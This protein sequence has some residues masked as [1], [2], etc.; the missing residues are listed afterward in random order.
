M[1]IRACVLVHVF[2]LQASMLLFSLMQAEGL[3]NSFA[4]KTMAFDNLCLDF[5]GI[6]LFKFV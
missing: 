1:N 3:L 5:A 6:L 2:I 4:A